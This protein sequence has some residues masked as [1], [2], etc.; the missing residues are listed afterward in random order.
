MY[1]RVT[2]GENVTNCANGN[3][4]R[5]LLRTKN[6]PTD[7]WRHYS[8]CRRPGHGALLCCKFKR[9]SAPC[10]LT[11]QCFSAR[12]RASF[13]TW[14]ISC[15][16]GCAGKDDTTTDLLESLVLLFFNCNYIMIQLVIII[17]SYIHPAVAA[18]T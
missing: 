7:K 3:C 8:C 12:W 9:Y 2:H 5:R 11:L 15:L 6:Q 18:C 16:D 17:I 14:R 4:L 10:E 1:S 13:F